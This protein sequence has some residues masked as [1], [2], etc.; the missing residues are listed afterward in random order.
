[1]R[2]SF[3]LKRSMAEVIYL[4]TFLKTS[5]PESINPDFLNRQPL[6]QSALIH[7]TLGFELSALSLEP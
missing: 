6:Y 4:P 1:M 2:K 5:V 7:L 3:L